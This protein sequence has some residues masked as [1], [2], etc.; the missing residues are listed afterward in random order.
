MENKE[1]N[2]ETKIKN[3]ENL[4][5]EKNSNNHSKRDSK[6]RFYIHQSNDRMLTLMDVP[7][8]DYSYKNVNKKDEII[9]LQEK[10]KFLEEKSLKL[11]SMNKIYYDIIKELNLDNN[12]KNNNN[13]LQFQSFDNPNNKTR[14]PLIINKISYK[15]FLKQDFSLLNFILL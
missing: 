3:D 2:E 7:D 6:N 9:F 8:E 13:T 4:I 5:I 12:N 11:E 15:N 14:Y 1:N 10:I